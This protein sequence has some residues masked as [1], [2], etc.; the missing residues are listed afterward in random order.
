MD[1]RYGSFCREVLKTC[2]SAY[3]NLVFS[4]FLGFITLLIVLPAFLYGCSAGPDTK[5]KAAIVR[6]AVRV[7]EDCGLGPLDVF[8]FRNDA[9]QS[10]DCYQKI[11]DVGLWDGNIL[12]SEGERTVC[13]CTNLNK[14]EEWFSVSSRPYLDGIM[15][16]LEDERRNMPFMYGEASGVAGSPLYVD[17][18]PHVSEIVLR[19]ISCD[20]SGR[21]YAGERLKDV[22]VYLTNVS[23]EC[24]MTSDS[25]MRPVRIINV[26]RLDEDDV[27]G[28]IEPDMIV[29]TIESE[30]G[31]TILRP[32]IRLRCY[33]N[34]SE[35][36]TPGT[37]YTRLVVEGKIG[38][39]IYYWPIDINREDGGDGVHADCRYVYDLKITRKGSDDPDIPVRAENVEIRFTIKPWEEKE[40]SVVGF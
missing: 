37:P 25:S 40:E 26:G 14:G 34:A 33:A 20:F 2:I 5:A 13:I 10:L 18:R 32:D 27:S 1:K 31:K 16:R 7:A 9:M 8:V 38:E 30:I 21:P 39:R 23:A 28:F 24:S 6:F 15:V 19:S 22:K 35:E 4:P 12:S 36:E 17:L 3:S 11:G 29:Q